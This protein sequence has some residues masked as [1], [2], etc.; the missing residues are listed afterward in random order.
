[1]IILRIGR[2]EVSTLG[3]QPLLLCIACCVFFLSACS[4]KVDSRLT[5]VTDPPNAQIFSDGDFVG[6]SPV[7]IRCTRDIASSLNG[8]GTRVYSPH[9]VKAVKRGYRD[10]VKTLRTLDDVDAVGDT[11]SLFG[12]ITG[13]TSQNLFSSGDVGRTRF[14]VVRLVLEKESPG[15]AHQVTKSAFEGG[16][17]GAISHEADADKEGNVASGHIAT[18]MK[19][20]NY[21]GLVIGNNDYGELKDLWTA[22][23]DAQAVGKILEEKYAFRVKTLL[24]ATRNDIIVELNRYRNSLSSDDNL[25]IYY[26]GHGILDE[27]TQV[28][29][30][31]PVDAEYGN[32]ANWLSNPTLTT[33]IKAIPAKHIFIISDS[34]FSGTLIRGIAPVSTNNIQDLKYWKRI[35]EK[36]AR[37]VLTS[38]GLE[39]VSDL[40]SISGSNHSVFAEALL[41]VLG[42]STG[43]MDSSHLFDRIRKKVIL[44]AEQTPEYADVRMAGHDGGEFI[45]VGR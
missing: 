6:V 39:P 4:Q 15:T 34:C 40:G 19:F 32:P 28:G 43:L 23:N 21:Y 31:L 38:G 37:V 5:V 13:G 17:G 36:R 27:D 20:G 2:F 45:F 41:S 14:P 11:D 22:G 18:S 29:Y 12:V 30:W 42:E 1:M 7:D 9:E 44:N 33:L 3:S 10:K 35:A 8:G 24:N 25:L 26:A 16:Y